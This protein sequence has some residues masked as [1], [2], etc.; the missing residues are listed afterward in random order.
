M[1]ALSLSGVV[2]PDGQHQQLWIRDGRISFDPVPGA[3]TV[4]E[5]GYVLPGLVDAHCHVGIGPQ[6]PV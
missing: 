4:F 2:L 6:G 3:E 1:T 5:G